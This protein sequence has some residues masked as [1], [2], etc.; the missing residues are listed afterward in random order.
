VAEIA[1]KLGEGAI[2]KM[3][4]MG[5]EELRQANIP[6]PEPEKVYDLHP[7]RPAPTNDRGMS[8]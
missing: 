8:R 7:T 6:Q 1:K 5:L 3:L 2:T 4:E